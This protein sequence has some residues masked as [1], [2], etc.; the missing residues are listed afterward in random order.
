V[1]LYCYAINLEIVLSPLPLVP[2]TQ[3][4]TSSDSV[5]SYKGWETGALLGGFLI[6]RWGWKWVVWLCL[7]LGC[8]G[9]C[10]GIRY[11]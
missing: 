3:V 2:E 7:W 11:L 4:G 10:G 5:Y 6:V 1:A 9:A 8:L